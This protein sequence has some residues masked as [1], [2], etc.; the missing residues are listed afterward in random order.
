MS[1]NIWMIC[2]EISWLFVSQIYFKLEIL[3]VY[4]QKILRLQSTFTRINRFV[5]K[6]QCLNTCLTIIK[7]FMPCF[8]TFFLVE[9]IHKFD[10]YNSVPIEK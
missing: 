1:Y 6:L 4:E 8:T 3:Q 9:Y 2:W 7:Y 10:F 5:L